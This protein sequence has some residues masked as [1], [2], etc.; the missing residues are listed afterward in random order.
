MNAWFVKGPLER[1]KFRKILQEKNVEFVEDKH[2]TY[3]VFHLGSSWLR[4]L[5]EAGIK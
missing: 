3:S 1:R 2:L 4:M 5:L